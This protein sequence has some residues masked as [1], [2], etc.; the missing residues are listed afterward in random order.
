LL[1]AVC[2]QKIGRHWQ[3]DLLDHFAIQS[4]K[5]AEG[6]LSSKAINDGGASMSKFRKLVPMLQT[7]SMGETVAWYETYWDSDLQEGSVKMTGAPL[8]GM[9]S[10]LC[11]FTTRISDRPMQLQPSISR[12][13]MLTPY[14]T[15]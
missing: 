8:A 10:L 7:E 1:C 15:K 12:L 11:S 4:V 14:G 9:T 13:M 6:G 5:T 2:F 3:A